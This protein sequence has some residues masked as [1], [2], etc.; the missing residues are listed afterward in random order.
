MLGDAVT[1]GA[2]TVI[3]ATSGDALTLLNLTT[4]TLATARADFNFM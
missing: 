1:V 4:S 2:D 3:P